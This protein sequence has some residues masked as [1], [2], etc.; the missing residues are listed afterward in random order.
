MSGSGLE[1]SIMLVYNPVEFGKQYDPEGNFIRH[2]LPIL[3][4]F[5]KEYIYEPW[6]VLNC[7]EHFFFS[8]YQFFFFS[9]SLLIFLSFFF[10]F[11]FFF[12][13]KKGSIGHSKKCRMYCWGG[14]P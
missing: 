12:F 1:G 3:K 2:Y 10:F 14:L 9:F 4:K 8:H 5:P 7:D 13:S 11:F 6:K